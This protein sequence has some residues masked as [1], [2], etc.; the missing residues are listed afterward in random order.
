MGAVLAVT[1]E[2]G[3]FV[4]LAMAFVGVFGALAAKFS[5]PVMGIAISCLGLVPFS[6]GLQT[7]VLP[8]LFGDEVLLLLYLAV[9]PFL[10][11]FTARR[12]HHGFRPLYLLLAVFICAQALS[13]AVATDLVAFRNFLET[14]VLGSVLLVV[15]LQEASNN[16]P[17][18]M[19]NFVVALTV[20]IAMLSIAERIIQRNPVMENSNDLYISAQLVQI[21]EGVYRPYVSFFHPSEAGTFMALGAPFAVRAWMQQR[22]WLSFVSVSIVAA[23][24]FVNA[25]RGVWVGVFVAALLALLTVRKAW[26]WLCA[27]VPFVAIG[28]WIGYMA[29]ET[30]PFMKRLTDSTDLYERFEFWKI[31]YRIFVAHPLIGVGHMQFKDVYLDYVKDLGSWTYFDISKVF[32][33]DNMFLTTIVEHGIVGLAALIAVLVFLAVL[34]RRARRCLQVAGLTRG[35]SFVRCSELALAIYVVTGCLAD[36]HLFT[37]A[38]KFVFILTALGLAEGARRAVKAGGST[39][40]SRPPRHYSWRKCK[41]KSAPCYTFTELVTITRKPSSTT[42]FCWT[43]ISALMRNGSCNG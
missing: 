40:R 34:L 29:F 5:T 32:V 12:W 7:G 31:A 28:A 24:L 17:E 6:W 16:E 3:I 23:G 10:Y 21:T 41:P 26:L 30:S 14:F 9:F 13:F 25:T 15:V 35:V 33:A 42:S 22:T 43:W 27:A 11:L 36:V 19:G 37:K 38:T 20:V 2:A 4:L 1:G 39:Q 8:K 18:R